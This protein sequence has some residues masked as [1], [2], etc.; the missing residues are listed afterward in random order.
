MIDIQKI[1]AETPSCE[2]LL[3]FNNAGA[4]LM[5]TCV[6]EAVTNH[7]KSE[8]AHGG[9]EAARLA[10]DELDAFY[11]EFAGLLNAA[12]DEIAYVE[13]ATRAWDMA[14]YGLPLQPGDRV[15]THSAE[16]V[17]N[18]LAL[19][20]QAKLRGIEIDLV[21]SDVFGQVDVAA[22]EAMITPRTRLIALTHVPT[23]G[24]LVNPAVEVGK[25]ARKHGLIYMLDACQSVGQMVVDVQEIGCDI[26]SGTGRKF[27][28]GP[29]GTGFLYVRREMT[30]QIEPPFI[31]LHSA[32]WT[33][34]N[35]YEISND[36]KRFE[37]WE[38]F[39]AGR[40]GLMTA[41]RYAREIGLK[42]IEQHVVGLAANLRQEL[43]GVKGVT[44]HDLGQRK[45]GIV[46]FSKDGTEP[47]DIAEKLLAQ[48]INVSVSP[49]GSA[50]LDLGPR[51]LN[52]L[53]RASVHYFN[54]DAEIDRFVEAINAI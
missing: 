12:P 47:R 21:P 19:L 50:R 49:I 17:S 8:N 36:A 42:A 48:K 11:T 20:Q 7:L 40:I 51:G 16:Y 1:R 45:C 34:P 14:F 41:V 38:S 4:S 3:H 54:T 33:G 32:V 15:L 44:V 24:G 2:N 18:Y 28:R 23:H 29:R 37:N 5:P 27:L 35:S 25:V 13:N 43:D 46:T 6:Y 30:K 39:V 9:Y 10:S 31:D 26:L 52:S 53:T 22:L